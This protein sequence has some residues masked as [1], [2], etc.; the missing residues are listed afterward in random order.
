MDMSKRGSAL[1]ALGVAL[2]FLLASPPPVGWAAATPMTPEQS[3]VLFRTTAAELETDGDLYL[4]LNVTNLLAD[5]T[6][7]LVKIAEAATVSAGDRELTETAGRVRN[8]L[9]QEGVLDVVAIG[10][11]S[12]P[13][14]DGTHSVRSL[15]LRRPVEPT[16]R[17]WRM[18]GDEPRE[19]GVLRAMPAD[20]AALVAADFRL[21]E[22]WAMFQ[23]G[24]RSIGGEQA[25]E[26]MRE[27]IGELKANQGIDVD[28]AFAAHN[29][30]LAIAVVLS[31][32]ENVSLPMGG[33]LEI[34]KPGLL[35]AFGVRDDTLKKMLL[36]LIDEAP[37]ETET[38]EGLEIYRGPAN[39]DAPFPLQVCAAQAGSLFFMASH[40]DTLKAALLAMKNGGGLLADGEFRQLAQRLPRLNNGVTYVTERFNRTIYAIQDA[41]MSE[42]HG[43]DAPQT[44]ILRVIR[45]WMPMGTSLS[46]R[47]V[48]PNGIYMQTEGPSG[49]REILASLTA[50]PLT[51]MLG[52]GLPAIAQARDRAQE[53]TFV[54]V[55]RIVDSAKDQWAMENN[56]DD[57]AEPT[58]EDLKPYIREGAL[59]LPPGFR[60]IVRPVGQSPQIIGPDGDVIEL[61]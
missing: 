61:P 10:V 23:Q 13:R 51:M 24:V 20:T 55:L 14:G 4:H 36:K 54:N 2:S 21:D 52:V 53:N 29:G 17:F 9:Q 57:G 31:R 48:K 50:V 58:L 37:V 43:A 5:F 3:A 27:E 45:D 15:L 33:N 44:R 49:A 60:I 19:L 1:P 28:A 46:V 18:L 38:F 59:D 47:V 8:F 35:A 6:D 22:L 12:K 41:A 34:P 30:E 56:K 42:E 26:K 39:D 11:S 7:L 32:T 40:P 25:Y 16:P